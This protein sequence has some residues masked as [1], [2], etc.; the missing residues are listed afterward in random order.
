M[1]N[2]FESYV[3][4]YSADLTRLCLSLCGNQPDAEDLFQDT[5]V[6]AMRH[7]KRY[8]EDK[9]FDKW[10]FAICVNTYKNILTSAVRRRTYHFTS[11]E[12]QTAFFNAIPD[13][14]D[15]NRDDYYALHRAIGALPK[16]QR[17][18]I[19]LYYFKDYS[20]KEISE[21]THV[22]EGTVKSRLYTAKQSIRRRL[23]HEQ[24]TT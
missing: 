23:E 10:L 9:P 17:V 18:C 19:V 14:N 3:Q 1:K 24:T 4:R 8:T 21:I 13:L 22:P 11:G 5:W 15:S 16:K 7:F 2:K 20:V 12:E 6:K